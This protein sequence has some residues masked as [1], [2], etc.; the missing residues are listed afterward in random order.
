MEGS[1][2]VVIKSLN[3]HNYNS[4]LAISSLHR[5][6][7]LFRNYSMHF[8]MLCVETL[9]KIEYL[10]DNTNNLYNWPQMLRNRFA[11][12]LALVCTINRVYIYILPY[13]IDT[14]S[15]SMLLSYWCSTKYFYNILY[16]ILGHVLF[17]DG[18]IFNRL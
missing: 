4:K 18:D 10:Y 14:P 9:N 15:L 17:N 7:L 1:W 12:W 5:M 2:L 11:A 8:V 6:A 13:K 3:P 16:V